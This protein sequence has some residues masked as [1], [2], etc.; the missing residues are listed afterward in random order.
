MATT[1]DIAVIMIFITVIIAWIITMST[2]FEY[3]NPLQMLAVT[4][5]NFVTSIPSVHVSIT[6]KT[7]KTH[8]GNLPRNLPSFPIFSSLTFFILF[9]S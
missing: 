6:A 7:I 3:A 9:T 8:M 5:W 4:S 1:F 2:T